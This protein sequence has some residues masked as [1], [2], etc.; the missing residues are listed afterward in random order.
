[1]KEDVWGSRYQLFE[2]FWLTIAGWKWVIKGGE[3]E[4]KKKA[5][6][7][8]RKKAAKEEVWHLLLLGS[9]LFFYRALKNLCF[10][11]SRFVR[12]LLECGLM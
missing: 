7:Q 12:P 10:M 8:A 5:D 11:V 3:D 6:E 2:A 4:L 1:M 9:L